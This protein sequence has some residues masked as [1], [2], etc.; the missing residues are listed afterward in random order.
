MTTKTIDEQ[1]QELFNVVATKTQQLN[2][3][4]KEISRSWNTT[5][6]IRIDGSNINLQT[7]SIETIHQVVSYLIITN[8]ANQE[9]NT[10]LGT[11]VEKIQGFAY[12]DWIQDCKKRIATFNVRDQRS[13]LQKLKDR[14]D[15]IIS[16]EQ[17]RALELAAITKE[18]M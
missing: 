8:R 4:E 1:I 18:L 15:N 14:L 10:I 5:C 2:D 7:A 11:K 17:R 13:N 12:D 16:P 6:S 9:A 3:T